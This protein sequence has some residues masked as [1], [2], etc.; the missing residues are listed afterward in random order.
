[1][2]IKSSFLIGLLVVIAVSVATAEF[3]YEDAV[4]TKL[5]SIRTS[6]A[7][8]GTLDSFAR[9]QM[10]GVSAKNGTATASTDGTVPLSAAMLCILMLTSLFFIGEF[11]EFGL[12]AYEKI[13]TAKD[14]ALRMFNG[15]DSSQD[16]YQSAELN[17]KSDTAKNTL[18]D[19]KDHTEM[20]LKSMQLA[21]EPVPMIAILILFAHYRVRTD[22]G[23]TTY[24]GA[25]DFEQ[26]YYWLTGIVAANLLIGLLECMTSCCCKD[27]G[28]GNNIAMFL[29]I[30]LEILGKTVLIG[31][32]AALIVMLV[33]KQHKDFAQA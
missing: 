22:L 28:T 27:S 5:E 23:Y 11:V 16:M 29:T 33:A 20:M 3:S 24:E 10:I 25:E 15:G 8:E 9:F 14:R 2:A 13:L 18:T 26:A 21:L 6:S 12:I 17:A 31:A 7:R 4:Q 19:L 32:A 30:V 1:M